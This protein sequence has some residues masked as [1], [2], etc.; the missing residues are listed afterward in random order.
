V[1]AAPAPFPTSDI[2]NAPSSFDMMTI[3]ELLMHFQIYAGV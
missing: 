1:I 2:C 3:K